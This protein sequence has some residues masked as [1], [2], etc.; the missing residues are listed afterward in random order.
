MPL[1]RL[2]YRSENAISVAGSRILI[3]FH[4][5]VSNARRKNASESISGFLM[6]DRERYHQIL[7]GEEQTIDRLWERLIKDVRHR[8][9]EI[10]ERRA[11]ATRGFPEWSMGSFLTGA[12]RHPLQEKHDITPGS[13]LDAQKFLAFALEF[14]DIEPD[15]A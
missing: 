15:A 4:D 11:I 3:H 1:I 5:I 10:L 13:P 6:F 14:V 7:E 2:I 8:N 12:R 9:I